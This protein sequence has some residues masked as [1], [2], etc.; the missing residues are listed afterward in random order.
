M[1]VIPARVRKKKKEDELS[2]LAW[3]KI[4]TLSPTYPEQ[5]G[6]EMW[7]KWESRCFPRAK[8]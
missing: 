4:R 1:P 5:K 2:D 8:L 6:L 7:L 3:E